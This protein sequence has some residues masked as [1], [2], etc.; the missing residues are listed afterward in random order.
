MTSLLAG[1]VVLVLT[2]ILALLS[3][4]VFRTAKRLGFTLFD[5]A[6]WFLSIALTVF[7]GVLSVLGFAG[8]FT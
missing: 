4:E 7:M 8:W 2:V 6:V 1:V 5:R 3:R